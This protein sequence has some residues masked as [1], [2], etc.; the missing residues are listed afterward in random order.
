MNFALYLGL[1][2][3]GTSAKAAAFDRAGRARGFGRAVYAPA[4]PAAGWAEAPIEAIHAAAQAAVRSALRGSG[5]A[6]R[7]MT[8]SSQGQTFAALD[9]ADRPLYPA[10]MWYDSRAAAQAEQLTALFAARRVGI[11]GVA[12]IATVAKIMWLKEHFPERLRRARRYL[13]L[14]DYFAY[15]LAGRAMVDDNTAGSTGLYLEK[16]ADFSAAALAA[17]GIARGQMSEVAPPGT[18][19]GLILPDR[20]ADWGLSPETLLVVGTNDQYAGALGAGNCRPG[21]VTV[22]FGTC[23][24]LLTLA[25]GPS[26]LL[27]PG[28]FDGKFPLPDLRYRLAFAKTAGVLL[29]WFR[30]ELGGHLTFNE[31]NAAA[32]AVPP[33]SRGLTVCP[34]FDGRISPAPDGAM[35]GAVLHLTLRHTRGDV[36]RA[37]LEALAFCLRE[38]LELF[39]RHGLPAEI[40]RVIGGGA[41]NDFWMQMQADISERDIERPASTEAA[42]LGA[43]MLAMAGAG[44]PGTDLAE[45]SASLY[46]AGRVFHP[47]AAP[48]AEY[49]AAYRR[50][51]A[52]NAVS[53]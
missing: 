50:Y 1:D 19:V 46:R 3:G 21:I 17:C 43:A 53:G 47:A 6:V 52:A 16:N 44:G 2:L 29:D 48:A 27:P 26:G 15:H 37:L 45:I 49:T 36:Y 31:L 32:Q 42:A 5:G 25:R 7:A 11:E 24:A 38:N 9:E 35:R 28:I 23:L 40:V 39:S 51:L 30:R 12:P 41:G 22:T 33:G 34:H 14:P 4:A 8:V 13:L 18:P 20:A 10:I